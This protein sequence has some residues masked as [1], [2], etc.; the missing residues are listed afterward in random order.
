LAETADMRRA[1]ERIKTCAQALQ[2]LPHGDLR[3][4]T[5]TI[6]MADFD[7]VRAA[8]GAER[9]NVVGSS[10]GTRAALEY[11]RQFPQ[12]VRSAVLDGVA[13]PDMVLPAS[14]SVDNQRAFDAM[15]AS[16]TAD[17]R[18]QA[19]YPQLRAQWNQIVASLPRSVTVTHPVT[20]K[21]ESFTLTRDVMANL[22]RW[23]L[24]VPR[25]TAAL[26]DAIDAAAGG[27]FDALMALA[28][29]LQ[30]R[31]TP[32]MAQGMHFS[33]VCAEDAPRLGQAPDAPG[34]DF[35]DT[36]ASMYREVC[37]TWP[38]G[39]VPEAFYRVGPLPIPTLVLSGGA[40]PATPQRHGERIAQALGPTARHVVVPNVG[41]GTLALLCVSELVY[42]FVDDKREEPLDFDCAAKLPR[43]TVY[44]APAP[45]TAA[46]K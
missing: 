3:M 21:P 4:Y 9:I 22:V 13:P 32:P 36:F 44:V 18:C 15:F 33:V 7:A 10:Y 5:T 2:K 17:A 45:A 30:S 6:A 31:R 40:D 20:G 19:R 27:R 41:H 23:P 35:G 1:T 14:F 12:R 29:S 43:A 11:M 46:A 39:E 38:R 8:L 26:P 24:Y 34:A 42:R 37:A 28:S 16:C 25:L